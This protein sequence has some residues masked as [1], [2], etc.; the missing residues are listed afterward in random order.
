MK[1]C[2]IP[3]PRIFPWILPEILY[4]CHLFFHSYFR[5]LI[6]SFN[7]WIF[8]HCLP[9]VRHCA[10]P[11]RQKGEWD[12]VSPLTSQWRTQTSRQWQTADMPDCWAQCVRV[13]MYA[14]VPVCVQGGWGPLC[15]FHLI[16]FNIHLLKEVSIPISQSLPCLFKCLL[17]TAA[18][19]FSRCTSA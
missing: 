9:C 14:C 18:S 7:Q 6:Y 4:P 17:Y 10:V 1:S 15:F 16:T 19:D 2:F 3:K 11:L 5:P 8:M 13:G 12:S